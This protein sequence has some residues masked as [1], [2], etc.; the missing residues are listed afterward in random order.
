LHQSIL[1][2][3][4]TV[5][6]FDRIEFRGVYRVMLKI[7]KTR[8]MRHRRESF[9][10]TL[11][12]SGIEVKP[13]SSLLRVSHTGEVVPVK[14]RLYLHA[15]SDMQRSYNRDFLSAMQS[16]LSRDVETESPRNVLMGRAMRL[17]SSSAV[18][19]L[20]VLQLDEFQVPN[21][22]N[23]GSSIAALVRFPI[24]EWQVDEWC[25]FIERFV[26]PAVKNDQGFVAVPL[27]ENV[28]LLAFRKEVGDVDLNS[29]AALADCCEAWEASHGG[30][31]E[32]F[33]DFPKLTD[34]NYNCLFFEILM[35]LSAPPRNGERI[36][37]GGWLGL[38]EAREAARIL[39][40][41]CRRAHLIDAS[42]SNL[43]AGSSSEEAPFP[44][45]D[46]KA[47]VWRHW[48]STLNQMLSKMRP[49]DRKRVV[50]TSLPGRVSTAG[51]WYVGIP[52]H[53]AAPDVGLK[54][55][56]LLTTRQSELERMSKGV[57][58]PTRSGFY[59]SD[60]SESPTP[61]SI[62]PYF[63]MDMGVLTQLVQG[64]FRRSCID[65]YGDLGGILASNLKRILEIPKVNRQ[66]LD[67]AVQA[68]FE[69]VVKV[70]EFLRGPKGS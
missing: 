17:G 15:E 56:K 30:A 2:N 8:H 14:I 55:I 53:S 16:T 20:Q 40:Q 59:S 49:A 47:R 60:S 57:G 43:T 11:G 70:V 51:E 50:V 61:A 3:A 62:S 24:Q 26:R 18:D 65:S 67:L 39:R 12:K 54:I 42:P 63:S 58:L 9:E 1:D 36:Q 13:T 21:V 45:V 52:A 29:W 66:E 22:A 23:C 10:L 37:L 28:S 32:L 44:K 64:A 4:D 5:I 6:E 48:Y 7:V 25:D 19:E 31:R 35:S 41:L 46:P 27:Y 68:S 69:S 34:E 38:C 33:F